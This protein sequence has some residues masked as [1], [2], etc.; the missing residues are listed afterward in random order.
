[1]AVRER[2]A[3]ILRVYSRL[4]DAEGLVRIINTTWNRHDYTLFVAHNGAADGFVA[5]ETLR[6]AGHYVAV[7]NNAG[8][9]RGAATLVQAGYQ[10]ARTCGDFSAYLFIE[11]DFWLLGD[12]LIDAALTS[13]RR[14]QRPVASTIWVERYHSLAVDFLLIDGT[15]LH[16]NPDL[17]AWDDHP[18]QYLAARLYPDRVHILECLRPTHV[19]GLLRYMIPF[20]A[21]TS[22]KGRFRLFP[23]APA[24]THHLEDLDADPFRA[25]TIKRG[26]ANTLA[27]RRVFDEPSLR[28]PW[29]ATLQPLARFVPQS[30]WFHKRRA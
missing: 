14:E 2:I 19:P 17:L 21:R 13:M 22:V 8:H 11:A 10:T 9:I 24:L 16:D 27:G 25:I 5:S 12:G 26:L 6:A 20:G 3:V 1:M 7:E 23:K 18:E 30:A 29:Q 4:L 15:F 28:I